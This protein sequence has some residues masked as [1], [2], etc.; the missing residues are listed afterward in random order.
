MIETLFQLIQDN[1]NVIL[2]RFMRKISSSFDLTKL[3][4]ETGYS[5]LM[6]A[7]SI[8]KEKN[9]NS[10]ILIVKTLLLSLPVKK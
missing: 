2:E 3:W 8:T 9:C 4:D 5:P 10:P 7:C 6:R 1:N